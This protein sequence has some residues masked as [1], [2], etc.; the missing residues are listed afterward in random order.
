MSNGET[1][2]ARIVR[3]IE[4]DQL[5]QQ[6]IAALKRRIANGEDPKKILSELIALERWVT[7]QLPGP[8]TAE[9]QEK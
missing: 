6:G 1:W 8:P 3:E 5:R 4:F 7:E 9:S 2:A